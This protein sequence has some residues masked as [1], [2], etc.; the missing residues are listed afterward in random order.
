MV[1]PSLGISGTY[2]RDMLLA[3]LN[4]AVQIVLVWGKCPGAWCDY[5]SGCVD[6]NFGAGD[7]VDRESIVIVPTRRRV[8]PAGESAVK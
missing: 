1:S 6:T 7:S 8:G 4:A 2:P 5:F 3:H